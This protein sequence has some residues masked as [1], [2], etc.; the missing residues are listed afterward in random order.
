MLG[1]SNAVANHRSSSSSWVGRIESD[2]H[3]C[4]DA[5]DV[6]EICACK[7]WSRARRQTE[8]EDVKTKELG[9]R[10]A[11]GQMLWE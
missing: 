8:G 2:G 4:G 3:G 10:N 11:K 7:S 6:M 9:C 5:V 1:N